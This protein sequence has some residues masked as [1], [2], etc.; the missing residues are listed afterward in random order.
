M[1]T[2]KKENVLVRVEG[3]S[4][5]FCK[6]LKRSLWY[7][8]K[9]MYAELLGESQHDQLR[10]D[11]FW[12][13]KDISFELRRGECLGLIGH[14]G[15]GKSTLLKMLNGLIR[16]DQ[17]RIEMR[18]RVAALIELAAGF[19]PILTGREN[20][21][22]KGAV[23]GLHTDEIAAKYDEIVAFAELEDFMEMPVQNY[24][25][26]MKARLG[27][28]VSAMMDPDVLIVDEVLAVGDLGFVIK[29]LNRMS[30]I[31][32]NA[33]V[34]FV[35]HTMPMV[36]RVC[37]KIL[38]MHGGR[39]EFLSSDIPLG[40]Q[41]YTNKFA[42]PGREEQGYGGV[43]LSDIALRKDPSGEFVRDDSYV[44]QNGDPLQVLLSFKLDEGI[45]PFGVFAIFLDQQM[46]EVLD[47]RSRM[48]DQV[49]SPSSNMLNLI[50]SLPHVYLNHGKYAI[51]VGAGSQPGGRIYCRTTN[52]ITFFS[53]CDHPSWATSTVQGK[54]EVFP[55]LDKVLHIGAPN[56]GD[57]EK[58]RPVR[59]D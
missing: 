3:V 29:C 23:M 50:I 58:F 18:G 42:N 41:L 47:T 11:E 37:S 44:H 12:A 56:I 32:P 28:A 22:N 10:P 57:R 31:T 46:R 15:A 54:W 6:S 2:N 43:Y 4:K 17:G 21:Y 51:T 53:H 59:L 16:P 39:E 26:G 1:D 45:E 33:A 19:N 30:Q 13:V 36:A 20:V 14:N 52:C 7:G 34:I 27:F 38:L 49:Y 8:V 9:D 24:S 48:A 55:M 35:S 40:I 5:K 25:S